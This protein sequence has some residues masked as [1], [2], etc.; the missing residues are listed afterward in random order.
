MWIL[1]IEPWVLRKSCQAVFLIA[2]PPL[3]PHHLAILNWYL[4]S[5]EL[6]WGRILIVKRKP[7]TTHCLLLMSE[8]ILQRVGVVPKQ[9]SGSLGRRSLWTPSTRDATLPLLW[10]TPIC[11]F[12]SHERQEYHSSKATAVNWT[13]LKRFI[14]DHGS[15]GA[16]HYIRGHM[17]HT[18]VSLQ[19]DLSVS[20]HTRKQ[21]QRV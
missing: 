12:L 3:W 1:E 8:E 14:S 6:I 10:E 19:C 13:Q 17:G 4:N 11:T 18:G 20:P 5:R 7:R 9:M 21:N 15:E 2:E 16:V